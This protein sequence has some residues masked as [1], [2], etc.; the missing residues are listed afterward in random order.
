MH[1][2]SRGSTSAKSSG[3]PWAWRIVSL[4]E[5]FVGMDADMTCGQTFE[6]KVQCSGKAEVCGV[7]V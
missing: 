3:K 2:S 5:R 6:E 7:S 1:C 4:F